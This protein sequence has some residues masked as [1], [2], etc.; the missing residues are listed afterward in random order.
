MSVKAINLLLFL[1]SHDF[2]IILYQE[3][4]YKKSLSINCTFL[5]TKAFILVK[6]LADFYKAVTAFF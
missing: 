4:T 2:Y 5:H 1:P 6:K 3:F